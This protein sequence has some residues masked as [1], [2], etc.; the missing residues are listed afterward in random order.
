[1]LAAV[2]FYGLWVVALVLAVSRWSKHPTVSALV[3]TAGALQI[4]A[5]LGRFLVPLMIDRAGIERE[6]MTMLFAGLG[7]IS[8]AGLGCLVAAVFS[9]RDTRA[10]P[11]IR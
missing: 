10:D 4:V 5:S 7:V 3:V 2:P 11:P 6:G 9:E 1:M 8:T